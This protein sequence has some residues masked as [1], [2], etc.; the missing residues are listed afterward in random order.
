MY[1]SKCTEVDF[2][3]HK[4][5]NFI[6]SFKTF[7]YR[8]LDWK[9]GKCHRMKFKNMWKNVLL[10]GTR[11]YIPLTTLASS[12][13]TEGIYFW[14][15]LCI[16]PNCYQLSRTPKIS[17]WITIS[18]FFLFCIIYMYCSLTRFMTV[19]CAITFV[20]S[21]VLALS[22]TFGEETNIT[23]WKVKLQIQNIMKE[24]YLK[25]IKT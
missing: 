11:Y 2:R 7:C 10:K 5:L 23:L 19:I 8:V 24:A 21:V 12:M 22:R 16:C 1:L 4:L 9:P 20:H 14:W 25:C 6:N 3:V 13:V 15:N 18:I 17:L